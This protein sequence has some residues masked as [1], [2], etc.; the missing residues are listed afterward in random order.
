MVAFVT[1]MERVYSPVRRLINSSTMLTQSVASIDRVFE[2]LNEPYDIVDKPDA[3]V[4]GRVEGI[5]TIENVSFR[6][7]DEE[8]DVLKNINLDV[9]KG[10]SEER[11]VGK[12]Y[13][14]R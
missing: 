11:R 14:S 10:R 1:Y 2:F 13:R 5:V 8:G 12:E 9:Q 3:K 7:E 4:L 6:Y